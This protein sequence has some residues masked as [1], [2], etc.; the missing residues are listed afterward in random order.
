M[1]RNGS[2]AFSLY[3]PG[4]PV[5]PD[6][7]I[8]ADWAN[9][10]LSDIASGL[11][12]SLSK[13][14]QTTA[15]GNLPMG[16][17]K[18]TGLSAG[19]SAGDSLRFEQLFSQGLPLD[20][21]SASTVDVGGQ[22]T[23][24]LNVTGTTGITSLGTNYNGPRVLKFS[25]SLTITHD[26]T[27]LVLPNGQNIT[28]SAND[29]A[30]FVPK[31]TSSGTADGWALISYQPYIRANKLNSVINGDFT[32][33]QRAV[34]GTVTLASGAYGHDRWKAG[35]GGCTYTFATSNGKTTITISSGSLQ[36]VIASN[37]LPSGTNTMVLS[38]E[39][40]AQGK[41][42][43]GSYSSSGVTA[44]VTGGSNLT[45]EF[46]TGTLTN[47]QLESG[48]IPTSFIYEQQLPF[49][50]EFYFDVSTYPLGITLDSTNLYSGQV[51]FPV[52]M[53][54][55]PTLVGTSVFVVDTGSVGN[56]QI[57]DV[58]RDGVV[59]RNSLA[60]WTAGTYVRFTGAFNAE[61]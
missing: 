46:N 35:S 31:S 5:V 37:Y 9:N 51:A 59:L 47:V 16:N 55:N 45:I 33:N 21:A 13:D 27:T 39:G 19:T 29:Y 43:S 58:S 2:G 11:T 41:I 52:R 40:T 3:T 1:P 44:S 15:T 36:Q 26:A 7:D 48:T 17:N 56:P 6:T 53:R 23:T 60:N 32:V 24:F 42:A 38:W 57:K 28:T 54:A 25:D 30:V 34:S 20:I 12:Q 4:N 22:N 61:L 50:R 8:E 10:T 18:L 49:C 14:G